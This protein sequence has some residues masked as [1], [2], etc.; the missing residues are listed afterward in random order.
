MTNEDDRPVPHLVQPY[1]EL[2][3]LGACHQGKQCKLLHG[4]LLQHLLDHKQGLCAPATNQ[5]ITADQVCLP[6]RSQKLGAARVHQ[7]GNNAPSGTKTK[8]HCAVRQNRREAHG[9]HTLAL[10]LSQYMR[11]AGGGLGGR[12][13]GGGGDNRS[14]SANWVFMPTLPWSQNP[15]GTSYG[16]PTTAGSHSLASTAK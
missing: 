7:K 14:M 6:Q 10:G 4:R 16:F 5:R 1:F 2:L 9:W 15:N 12:Q 13:K 3:V 11:E 8:T